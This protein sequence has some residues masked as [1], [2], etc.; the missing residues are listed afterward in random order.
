MKSAV[1]AAWFKFTDKFEGNVPFMYLDVKGLVTFGRGNLADPCSLALAIKWVHKSDGSPAMGTEIITDWVAVKQSGMTGHSWKDF[2]TVTKLRVD[3][4]ALDAFDMQ[5]TKEMENYLKNRPQ[6]KDFDYWPA[7]AQ[8]GLLGMAWAMGPAFQFPHFQ[9]ACAKQDW[10]TC[11]GK[12]GDPVVNPAL[13]GE[14]WMNDQGN[15]GL[16]PRN[17]ATRLCFQNAAMVMDTPSLDPDVL[18]WPAAA[19]A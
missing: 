9:A 1:E 8:L 7:D 11:A 15:P 17:L 2:E 10:Q 3:A 14:A 12:D 16:R 18:Y 13:R 6:F 5:K 4:E 19:R